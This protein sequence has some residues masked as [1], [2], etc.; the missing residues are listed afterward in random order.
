MHTLSCARVRARARRRHM[1]HFRRFG[2]I[3]V[4]SSVSRSTP[5]RPPD[6]GSTARS[7]SGL[8]RAMAATQPSA[9]AC[10]TMPMRGQPAAQVSP[11]TGSVTSTRGAA[12]RRAPAPPLPPNDIQRAAL[13]D[14]LSSLVQRGDLLPHAALLPG[15]TGY[16]CKL[17]P[18][19]A[20]IFVGHETTRHCPSGPTQAGI[21]ADELRC[22]LC[23]GRSRRKPFSDR[24]ACAR[25]SSTSMLRPLQEQ[26]PSA[27]PGT[28]SRV[29]L[30]HPSYRPASEDRVN[31]SSGSAI[32]H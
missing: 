32:A 2:A 5:S 19:C 26:T 1:R 20:T 18:C 27:V 14:V 7:P 3:R 16:Q 22:A 23:A 11:G 13:R 24:S 28:R 9:P 4:A 10:R 29:S 25:R 12:A 6:G 15:Q 21:N 30:V 31:E 17:W 8:T